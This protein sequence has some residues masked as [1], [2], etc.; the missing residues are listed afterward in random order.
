L[1]SASVAKRT[2]IVLRILGRMRRSTTRNTTRHWQK[3]EGRRQ[4]AE[5]ALAFCLLPSA[6]CLRRRSSSCRPWGRQRSSH[7]APCHR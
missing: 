1:P 7:R 3:A 6:F 4:K 5:G 2:R